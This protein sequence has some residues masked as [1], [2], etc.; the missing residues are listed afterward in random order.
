MSDQ[1]LVEVT[2]NDVV[3]SRHFGSAVVCDD[4]GKVLH[5]WGDVEKLIFPR[6][7]LKPLLAIDLVNSGASEHFDLSDAE[8]SMAC[9]SHQGEPM[10]QQLVSAW[11]ERLG[12]T[13][14]SLACGAVLPDDIDSAHQLLIAGQQGCRVHHNCS[15]KHAGFLTTALHLK[16][17]LGDFHLV[18]H[19]LQQLSMNGLSDLAG[20]NVFDYPSGVDGCGFPAPTMPLSRLALMVARFANPA[21]LADDRAQAIFRIQQALIREPLYAAGHGTVVS[22]LNQVTNGRVLAKTGAEGVLTVALP[23]Q[24]LGIAL[25]IADGSARARSTAMLAILDHL[26]VLSDAESQQL[27]AHAA[28]LIENSRGLVVGKIRAAHSWL[29]GK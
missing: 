21:D 26:G 28:P 19:P 20:I 7:A 4:R 29:R 13:E 17:P 1:L 18:E 23:E 15:G 9:A 11:L 16:M 3:E 24:G 8:I 12:L 25:K 5:G 14:D 6:S 10:H 22:E 27:Q 2:R